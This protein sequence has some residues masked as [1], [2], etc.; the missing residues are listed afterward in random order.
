MRSSMF[1]VA[2]AFFVLA[3]APRPRTQVTIEI[4]A[5][6]TVASDAI[7]LETRVEAGTT[8]WVERN[9]ESLGTFAS[10]VAFPVR[11]ALIPQ[12][13]DATRRFRF[14]ATAFDAAGQTLGTVRALSSFSRGQ[15]RTIR[16][17]LEECCRNAR[18]GPDQTCRSCVCETSMV[19]ISLSDAG[20]DA[21]AS[22][23]DAGVSRVDAAR[24][25]AS[26]PTLQDAF[27]PATPDAFTSLPD[28]S[29]PD[30]FT[31]SF[32]LTLNI[33]EATS[34]GG[35]FGGSSLMCRRPAEGACPS[36]VGPELFP[37][38][39]WRIRNARATTVTVAV[40][41]G[42]TADSFLVLYRDDSADLY[43]LPTAPV[44]PGACTH[45]VDNTAG[46]EPHARVTIDI[47]PGGIYVAAYSRV[48]PA[49]TGS[50]ELFASVL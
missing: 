27:T 15:T 30:A 1:F 7:R 36:T 21:G 19:P 13:G 37:C 23:V 11:A 26:V 33:G 3:C 29:S 49:A 42:G 5:E 47:P 40:S 50:V 43:S 4:D 6:G 48:D 16:L 24:G 10:P 20:I 32:V 25:D 18:C 2:S 38:S 44:D 46:L 9:V 8:D 12:S 22:R 17:V 28:A 45:A 35:T 41:T 31:R 14:E 34:G 39:V